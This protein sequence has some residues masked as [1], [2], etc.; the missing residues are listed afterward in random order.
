VARVRADRVF[1]RPAPPK[2]PGL[3]GRHPRHGTP[4]KC[5]D[6]ATWHGAAVEQQAPQP[7]H[8]PVQVMAWQRMHPM[9]HRNTGGF[10]DWPEDRQLP[11]IEGTLMRLS[12][13]S[14]AA[15][16]PALER[17]GCGPASRPPVTPW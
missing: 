5:A 7:R 14:R 12:V 2:A 10:E 15:G 9:V 16:C 17:C 1:Y 6:P 11:L 4:V 3:A 13:T 8:G